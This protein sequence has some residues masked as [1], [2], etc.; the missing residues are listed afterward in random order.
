MKK[1]KSF[2][3]SKGKFQPPYF[4]CT[5]LLSLSIITWVLKMFG[6]EVLSNRISD[7]FILGVLGFVLG[8]LATYNWDRKNKESTDDRN[9][10]CNRDGSCDGC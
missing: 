4:W 8:W 1:I 9:I 7:G 5:V 10:D 3:Y 2:F 6:P